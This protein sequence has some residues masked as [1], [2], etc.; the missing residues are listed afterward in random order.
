MNRVRR[1]VLE[2]FEL[3]DLGSD[4]PIAVNELKIRERIRKQLSLVRT[5]NKVVEVMRNGK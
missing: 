4:K 2:M 3:V 1:I 5:N